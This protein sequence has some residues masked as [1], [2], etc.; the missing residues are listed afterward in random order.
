[1]NEVSSIDRLDAELLA[2]LDADPRLPMSEL[3]AR[4]RVARNTV[5]ARLTRLT[6]AGVLEG[7]GAR[8]DLARLGLAVV[9][10]VHLE[11]AQGALQAV[12][13]E[14]RSRAHVLEVNATTGR[15]D[16]VVRIAAR[17]HPEL[18]AVLQDVLAVPGVLRT[19]TEIALSTPVPYRVAPLLS[20]LTEGSGR[21]R[22]QP[23]L[24]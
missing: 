14:L 22:A 11:L 15:S 9:A 16:L 20:A 7:F 1:M 6:D 8:V 23:P 13:D 12:I 18:Q 2:A 19:A 3:A 24:G 10:F 5:Q 4:L 17:S 21:G